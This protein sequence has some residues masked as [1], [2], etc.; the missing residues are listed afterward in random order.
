[1]TIFGPHCKALVP[2]INRIP[3]SSSI[4]PAMRLDPDKPRE[5]G[6]QA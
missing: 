1:M 5:F 4:V 3:A 2:W 6:S